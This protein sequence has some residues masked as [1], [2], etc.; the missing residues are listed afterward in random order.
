MEITKE[1]SIKS[2]TDLHYKI[3]EYIRLY[4]SNIII[5]PGLGEHQINSKIRTDAYMKGYK[6][7][8]PDILI[9]NQHHIYNGLAIELKT[10][11]NTGRLSSN[12][13]SYLEELK[14][15]N[16]KIII[17]NDYAFIIHELETYFSG[18]RFSC[19]H[20]SRKFTS[21][22]GREN[23]YLNFHKINT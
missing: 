19:I 9:L 8:S 21:I 18:I 14:M 17:S 13:K 22:D 4:F 23:H 2:E 1:V 12:Q 5:V 6:S 7:G 16:F 11:M 20:C 10:P 3:I 15:N